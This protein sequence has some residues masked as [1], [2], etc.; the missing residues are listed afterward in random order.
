[1]FRSLTSVILLL[2]LAGGAFL[3]TNKIKND[4]VRKEIGG[5]LLR[6]PEG[7]R[8]RWDDLKYNLFTKETTLHGIR[9]EKKEGPVLAKM[10]EAVLISITADF[11]KS[12]HFSATGV[13]LDFLTAFPSVAQQ[14]QALGIDKELFD[15]EMEFAFKNKELQLR[16]L[17]LSAPEI[18]KL[19]LSF[20][21]TEYDVYRIDFS[22]EVTPTELHRVS[23]ESLDLSFEDDGVTQ[24][25]IT[26]QA[27][28]AGK[29]PEAWIEEKAASFVASFGG[30]DV[31][32]NIALGQELREYLQSPDSIQVQISPRTPVSYGEM[33][34]A[35]PGELPEMLNLKIAE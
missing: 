18:G 21:I 33:L 2:A 20:A 4:K 6:M 5:Y 9:V 12:G 7:Y 31:E 3:I 15:V 32:Y 26:Q 13:T 29:E 10:E 27:R 28:A 30:E 16:N 1:M 23:L 8:L 35:K 24:R 19:R 34:F 22:K 25:Y 17:E 14:L 11:P